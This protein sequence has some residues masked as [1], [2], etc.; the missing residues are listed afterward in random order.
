[1]PTLTF[2]DPY[3]MLDEIRQHV[4]AT[5]H[6][7]MASDDINGV[8]FGFD[9]GGGFGYEC[10][11]GC[12]LHWLAQVPH[13]RNSSNPRVRELSRDVRA[14]QA[15]AEEVSQTPRQDP[16]TIWDRLGDDEILPP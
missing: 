11:S 12:Q 13:W 1:M 4:A 9:G 2:T 3:R 6:T 10:V 16:P 7:I 8:A 5:G 14:R 15:F